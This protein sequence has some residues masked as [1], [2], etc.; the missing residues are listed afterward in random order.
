MHPK[1]IEYSQIVFDRMSQIC[2]EFSEEK[3]SAIPLVLKI[4][5]ADAKEIIN[6]VMIALP[7]RY[8]YSSTPIVLNDMLAFISKNLVFF[9][10]QENLEENNYANHLL[11][12]INSLSMAIANRYYQK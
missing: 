9:Q 1:K 8:F 10:A 11:G 4:S 5:P 3:D 12:F 6:K 7:D 2:A